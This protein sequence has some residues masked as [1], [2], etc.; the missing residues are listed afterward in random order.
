MEA[1]ASLRI[2]SLLN[3]P[4]GYQ[5]GKCAGVLGEIEILETSAVCFVVISKETF[6]T[7]TLKVQ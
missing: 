5:T 4:E 3:S 1:N 7:G 6:N 2:G